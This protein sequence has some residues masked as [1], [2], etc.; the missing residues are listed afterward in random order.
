MIDVT[1]DNSNFLPTLKVILEMV[2]SSHN[3]SSLET[4]RKLQELA[5]RDFPRYKEEKFID[6][7][8][9][10]EIDTTIACDKEKEFEER[11]KIQ[12]IQLI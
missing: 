7:K 8:E 1:N 11:Y 3:I 2:N 4:K 12:L 6:D 5:D 10:E 9:E